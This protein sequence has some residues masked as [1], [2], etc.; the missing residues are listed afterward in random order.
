M[1]TYVPKKFVVHF[2]GDYL[3]MDHLIRLFDKYFEIT[4]NERAAITLLRNLIA[5]NG[6]VLESGRPDPG[7][8]C[9]EHALVAS[10]AFAL[11]GRKM[12]V[13]DGKLLILTRNSSDIFEVLPHKFL[14][15]DSRNIFDSSISFET[16]EGISTDCQ[17]PTPG[18]KILAGRDHPPIPALVQ[19][20]AASPFSRYFCYIAER[21]LLLNPSILG[22]V[23]DTPFGL[24]LTER[25]G[26]QSGL[27]AKAA[28]FVHEALD[29]QPPTLG[30]TRDVMWDAIAGSP[31]RD[32]TVA[33]ALEALHQM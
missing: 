21:P 27:W 1:P 25:F 20:L 10:L 18:S 11:A 12:L 17:K 5:H 16:I 30:D 7:W 6:G 3:G 32:D 29:G 28:W 4:M 26:S 8:C 31:N 22:M 13:C 14:V 24:W 2:Y 23:S 33:T 15:D 19:G 9:N